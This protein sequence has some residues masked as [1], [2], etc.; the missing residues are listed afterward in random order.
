MPWLAG[1]RHSISACC[2]AGWGTY[3]SLYVQMAKIEP[4][5]SVWKVVGRVGGWGS[6]SFGLT[7]SCPYAQSA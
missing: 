6:S 1:G 4:R 5:E 2:A 3:L 7:S